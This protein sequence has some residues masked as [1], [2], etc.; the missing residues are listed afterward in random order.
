ME[1]EEYIII[2]ACTIEI[3]NSF[4]ISKLKEVEWPFAIRQGECSGL[5]EIV[6]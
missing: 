3:I 4:K 1:S 5:K 6:A 2:E